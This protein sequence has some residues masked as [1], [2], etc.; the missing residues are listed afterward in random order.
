M[1]KKEKSLYAD[2]STKKIVAPN[3]QTATP[4]GK[5]TVGGDLRTKGGK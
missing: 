5:K 1:K 2:I 4:K 3:K